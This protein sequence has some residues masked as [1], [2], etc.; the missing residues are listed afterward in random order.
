M[1]GLLD[2]IG[3]FGCPKFITSDCGVQFLSNVWQKLKSTL[4]IE[5]N[6]GPLY[7]PQAVGMVERAHQTFK[8]H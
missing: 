7:R 4:G 8:I 3:H 2:F 5:L 1:L 6:T